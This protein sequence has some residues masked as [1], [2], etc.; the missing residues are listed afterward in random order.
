MEHEASKHQC[1]ACKSACCR[2]KHVPRDEKQLKLLENRLNRM[3]G[4]LG[5]VKNMLAENRYCGDILVQVAAVQSALE[6]FGQCILEEHMKT[7]VAEE[8]RNGNPEILD[9]AMQL[10]RKLK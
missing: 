9:E 8:I 4:Q 10:I 5:G 1:D 6:S 2:F 3:I 7:C